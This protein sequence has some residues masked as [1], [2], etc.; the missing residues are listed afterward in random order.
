MGWDERQEPGHC[1]ND[2]PRA[3]QAGDTRE[4]QFEALHD[5]RAHLI[6]FHGQ[7]LTGEAGVH[8]QGEARSVPGLA[9]GKSPSSS[10]RAPASR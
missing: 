9:G 8:E 1:S 3:S 5:L 10:M 2:E 7:H 4:Q 6:R